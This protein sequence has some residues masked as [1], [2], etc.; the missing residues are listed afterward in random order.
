MNN[1]PVIH[2]LKI[3]SVPFSEIITGQKKH[4]IRSTLDRKFTVGDVLILRE[5]IPCKQCHGDGPAYDSNE[6][7]ECGYPP[8]HG[9]YTGKLIKTTVTNITEPGTWGIPLNVCVMSFSM[10]GYSLSPLLPLVP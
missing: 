6:V 8:P 4:E 1:L 2:D 9:T 10:T 5:F 7:I 3:W